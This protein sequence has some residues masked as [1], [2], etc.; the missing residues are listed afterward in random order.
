MIRSLVHNVKSLGYLLAGNGEDILRLIIQ[1][2]LHQLNK[3]GKLGI[4]LFGSHGRIE[5]GQ[6]RSIQLVQAS[7]F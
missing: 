4:S 7:G 5:S 6:S 3:K 2:D 1:V